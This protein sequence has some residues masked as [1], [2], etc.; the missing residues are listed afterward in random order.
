MILRSV[1][2]QILDLMIV[3]IHRTESIIY[4]MKPKYPIP[5]HDPQTGEINPLSLSAVEHDHNAPMMVVFR[6]E[7]VQ[8]II[9]ALI[10]YSSIDCCTNSSAA[11]DMQRIELAARIKERTGVDCSDDLQIYDDTIYE[12]ED[13]A[14]FIKE[15]FNITRA[16]LKGGL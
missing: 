14:T 5:T 10:F 12:D 4:I 15:K 13:T 16:S 3:D 11:N 1:E 6:P 8:D 2:I 7:E 9:D